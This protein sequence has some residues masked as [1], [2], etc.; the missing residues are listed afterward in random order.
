MNENDI[1][2]TDIYS[3]GHEVI[4]NQHKKLINIINKL[5]DKTEL[6]DDVVIDVLSEMQKYSEYHFK[7]EEE[8]FEKYNYID[9]QIHKK[10]HGIFINHIESFKQEFNE[11][12]LT[13]SKLFEFLGKWL[14]N[15]ILISDK[16]YISCLKKNNEIK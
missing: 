13:R 14:I 4:D 16:R 5:G 3:V 9:T 6:N 11:G 2:W 15:H 1:R 12:Q 7:T 8:L 10:L